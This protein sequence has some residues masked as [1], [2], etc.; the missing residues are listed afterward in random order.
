M[1]QS[2]GLLASESKMHRASLI[3]ALWAAFALLISAGGYAMLRACDLE[4]LPLFGNAC[5]ASTYAGDLAIEREREVSLRSH[6]HAA[7]I[8]V[9]LI[10]VCPRPIMD[11]PVKAND[12]Q[13]VQKFE[14]PKNIEDLKGCWQSSRG[15]I[16]IV[17]DD[18]EQRRLGQARFCYCFKKNG[19]GIAQIRYAD[20][21]VCSTG[22]TARLL[23]DS[24]A[25]H[26]EAIDCRNNIGLVA[27]DITCRNDSQSKE[28]TCEIAGRGQRADKVVEQFIRVG[29]DY[30]GWGG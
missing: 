24:V 20:G 23:P 28:A 16:D 15:D 19:R 7:E 4:I 10:P 21:E 12:P 11:K 29:N 22:L 14:I 30:C 8:R 3:I 18:A 25:M 26:H 27:A 1:V 13:A 2:A 6:I 5:Q 9:A 17:S